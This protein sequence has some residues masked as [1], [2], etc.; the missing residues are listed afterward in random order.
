MDN[1]VGQRF[2]HIWA[3]WKAF[4]SRWHH[5]SPAYGIQPYMFIGNI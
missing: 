1:D 4:R 5:V 3:H 2:W